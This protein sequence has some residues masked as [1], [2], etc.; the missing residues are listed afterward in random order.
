MG[1]IYFNI[2]NGFHW[3]LS[4]KGTMEYGR[5]KKIEE[6]RAQQK[7]QLVQVSTGQLKEYGKQNVGKK[8]ISTKKVTTNDNQ[9]IT[10]TER[11]YIEW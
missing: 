6:K 9:T 10:N 8:S 4:Y 11:K 3:S 2:I 7:I 5:K 1:C